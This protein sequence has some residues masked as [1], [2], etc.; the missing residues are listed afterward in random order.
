M[1]R[2][3]P[4]LA[5]EVTEELLTILAQNP[6]GLGTSELR[7]AL[8]FLDTTLSGRQIIKVLRASEK[9]TEQPG[10][11]GRPTYLFWTLRGQGGK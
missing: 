11:H 9:V 8:K 6:E 5:K 1:R 4:Q 3:T 10:A 2:L 7:V